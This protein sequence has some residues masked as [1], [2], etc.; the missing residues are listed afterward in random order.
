[1]I[2]GL[3][4]GIFLTFIILVW[5]QH[6]VL[7]SISE[8]WYTLKEKWMFTLFCYSLGFLH[9]FHEPGNIL[10]MLAGFS[11][12][13]VGAA[14]RF[15]DGAYTTAIHIGGA[16]SAIILSF[17]A[18]AI[19]GIWLGPIFTG[20]TWGWFKFFNIKNRTWWVEIVA[21]VFIM[22]SIFLTHTNFQQF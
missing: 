13:F 8:S 12:I 11:L 1:M 9:L 16:I 15:K 20:L 22:L 10:Y 19:K 14:T 7:P 21:F 3:Q 6:G 17:I 5:S 18:L 4:L 2:L